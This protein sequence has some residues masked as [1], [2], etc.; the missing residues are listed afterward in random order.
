MEEYQTTVFDSSARNKSM[1]GRIRRMTDRTLW[2][3]AVSGS[4]VLMRRHG[5]SLILE[6]PAV[7]A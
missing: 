6:E 7:M 2:R 3:L 4:M 1:A 5:T